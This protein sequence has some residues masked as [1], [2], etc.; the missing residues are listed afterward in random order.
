MGNNLI[1]IEKQPLL[2]LKTVLLHTL[3]IYNDRYRKVYFFKLFMRRK[4]FLIK[5]STMKRSE[6]A[7][8]PECTRKH[9]LDFLLT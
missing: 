7:T 5:M 6:V 8:P 1:K 4:V 3:P 9:S 2:L